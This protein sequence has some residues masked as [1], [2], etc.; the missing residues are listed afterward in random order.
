MV[1]ADGIIVYPTEIS[2]HLIVMSNIGVPC[3][4]GKLMRGS[5]AA[6]TRT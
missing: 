5:N 4:V 3:A 6:S 2:A 1:P